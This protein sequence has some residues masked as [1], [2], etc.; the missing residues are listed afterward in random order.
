MIGRLD[1]RRRVANSI[2]PTGGG[3]FHLTT[4]I[5]ADRVL[6]ASPTVFGRVL[7]ATGIDGLIR[8][9]VGVYPIGKLFGSFRWLKNL[10]DV[11]TGKKREKKDIARKAIS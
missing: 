6:S 8:M 1:L 7:N 4:E 11:H 3:H 5:C 10:W 2:I 9:R